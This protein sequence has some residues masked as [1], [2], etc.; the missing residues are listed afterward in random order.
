M[1]TIASSNGKHLPDGFLLALDEEVS[2]T[3]ND[4]LTYNNGQGLESKD[5]IV[6]SIIDVVRSPITRLRLFVLV[7]V[8]FL[9]SVVYYGLTLNV[10][11]LKYNLYMNVMLNAVGEMPS[12]VITAMLVE[13]F[14]TV[15]RNAALGCTTQAQHIGAIL[16]PV[17]V[18]LG[19]Y[20]PFVVFAASGIVG[21]VFA[22]F[23]PETLN[24]PLYDTFSGMEVGIA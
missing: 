19:G 17:V 12:F 3:T 11:N 16:A 2:K 23:L 7:A 20:F 13:L 4:D 8:N 21:G 22:F 9:V 6:G 14:P 15:V 1:S 10:V 18:V 24:R 5:A